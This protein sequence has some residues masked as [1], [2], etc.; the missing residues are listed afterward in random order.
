MFRSLRQTVAPP[1]N[2][3]GRPKL[4]WGKMFFFSKKQFPTKAFFAVQFGIFKKAKIFGLFE[5]WCRIPGAFVR[6]RMAFLG[7][8]LRLRHRICDT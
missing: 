8:S 5:L 7:G 2:E 6:V 4:C 1:P 3:L